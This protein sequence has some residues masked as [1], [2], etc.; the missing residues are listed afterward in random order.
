M[1]LPYFKGD[2]GETLRSLKRDRFDMLVHGMFPQDPF[3]A[4]Y[5]DI[6]INVKY[7]PCVPDPFF[8][9]ESGIGASHSSNLLSASSRLT[10]SLFHATDMNQITLSFKRRML[11]FIIQFLGKSG[12]EGLLHYQF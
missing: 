1:L 6:P 7:I 2:G 3:L 12:G 9:M 10:S 8:L 11:N 4:N 5:L